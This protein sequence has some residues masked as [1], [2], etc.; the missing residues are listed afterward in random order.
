VNITTA[1]GATALSTTPNGSVG[2][3]VSVTLDAVAFAADNA[4]TLTAVV[5]NKPV[6][7][8]AALAWTAGAATTPIGAGSTFTPGAPAGP[9]IAGLVS[10]AAA[11]GTAPMGTLAVTPSAIGT[12]TIEVWHDQN[13]NGNRESAENYQTFTVVASAG[14]AIANE[15]PNSANAVAGA[16]TS[17]NGV[18]VSSV[19]IETVQVSGRTGIQVGFA[20]QYRLTRNAGTI[21]A[22]NEV[23]T[24]AG[25]FAT[26]AYSVTNP[27]GTAVTVV[28]AQGGTTA[29][30]SQAVA[31]LATP[32]LASAT[33]DVARTQAISPTAGWPQKGSLVYFAAAT[34]GTYTITAFHDANRDG[35]VSVGEAT[36]STTVVIAADALPSI[37]MTTYGQ[38]VGGTATDAKNNGV[39]HLVKIS[40]KNGTIPASLG[41]SEALTI[42]GP[43]GTVIDGRSARNADFKLAMGD[44]GEVATIDLTQ[45]NFDAAGNAYI[46]V[47]N[48][49]AGGGTYTLTATIAGG[50]AAGA[51]GSGTF[52]VLSEALFVPTV[53]PDK[54]TSYRNLTGV[55]GTGRIADAGAGTFNFTVERNKA[56]NVVIG[57]LPG[58]AVTATSYEATLTDTYGL[59]TG[60]IGGQY[61]LKG[62]IGTTATTATSVASWTV[63]VPALASTVTGTAMTLTVNQTDT[64]AAGAV[65]S[66]FA[67]SQALA[68]ATTSYTNPALDA[69]TFTFRAAVGSS[70]KLTAQV[71]N[72]FGLLMANVAVNAAV[73]GRNSTVTVPTMLT[74]AEGLVSF[75]LTDAS[76]STTL[77]TDTVTFTPAGGATSSVTINYATYLPADSIKITTPDSANATATG[78]AGTIKSDINAGLAGAQATT[79]TVTA[80]LKD[81]NGGTLPAGIPVTF[82]V[83]GAGAAILSTKVIGYTDGAG[84]VSTSVYA[85]KQVNAVVTAT[86]GTVSAS[87]TVYFV[88]ETADEARSVTATLGTNGRTIVGKA[89]DR[90]GNPVA[91]VNLKA[92]VTAGDAFFGTGTSVAVGE[93]NAAGEVTFILARDFSQNSTVVVAFNAATFGQST[94]A[95]GYIGAALAAN[96]FDPFVAG[97][98]VTAEEGVG[99]EFDAAGN[100]AAPAVTVSAPVPPAV[101]VVYDKPTLS[102]VKNGGRIIL[103]G[104]AVDGEGDIIIY[105]KKVGT[106]AWKERAKTLE[107]AAPGDFNGS[108]KAPKSDVLIRVK[109]EGTGLFSNQIIAVK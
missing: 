90:F 66:V 58:A 31:G 34:A 99:A 75:T 36:T 44:A 53:V 2:T 83:T 97:T 107:V 6:G 73:A 26:I 40:L 89:T 16:D 82:S 92:S 69:A 30:A 95:K 49:T 103:S 94:S 13:D 100:N 54:A 45:A 78:V 96:A 79:A 3:I 43:A 72:Q 70:H 62:T 46:N 101:E 41:L 38:S 60:L 64:S 91:G 25:R 88:Q 76:T 71:V 93:T 29:S 68:A 106:T 22:N 5:V 102:F 55:A 56:T 47:G 28:S 109:Q 52:T 9:T 15:I 67:I 105:I 59:I 98:T 80:V 24:M 17:L 1:T 61:K 11:T 18:K 42:T 84:S 85:W 104:T 81:A 23:P 4:V 14:G 86:V 19:G 51:T 50:T 35:L 108:I 57:F 65:D 39:G 63:P 21:T 32:L 27:A 12:Y 87:G 74:D 48:S 7:S 77:L 8:N 33:A 10:G 20:P 37:T